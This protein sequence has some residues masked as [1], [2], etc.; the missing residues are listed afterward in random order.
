MVTVLWIISAGSGF[1]RTKIE[2]YGHIDLCSDQLTFFFDLH[3][4][5]TF[6][7]H[8]G[9]LSDFSQKSMFLKIDQKIFLRATKN[10]KSYVYDNE[11]EVNQETDIYMISV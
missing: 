1:R 4:H 5:G 3:S 8:L 9:E 10:I 2:W 6:S 11:F 7:D